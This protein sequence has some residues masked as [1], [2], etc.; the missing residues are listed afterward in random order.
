[1]SEPGAGPP[2][3]APEGGRLLPE[4]LKPRIQRSVQFLAGRSLNQAVIGALRLGLPF[5]PYTPET[6]LVLE[7][8]GR[9][10]GKRRLTPM[11]C[12]REGNRLLVVAEHGRHADWVR[13]AL[14]AGDVKLWLGGKPHRA[15][16][17]LRPEDDPEELLQRMGNKLHAGTIHA[18]AHDPCVVA[19]ELTS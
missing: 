10:S 2:E 9:K 14:A 13:N 7:T 17:E 18:M 4:D 1:V 15:R 12:L 5:P 6:A 19:L 8:F 16:V 11:G 3:G